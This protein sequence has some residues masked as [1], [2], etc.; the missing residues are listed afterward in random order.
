MRQFNRRGLGLFMPFEV[1]W[2][3][4]TWT[5]LPIL[6]PLTSPIYWDL[7]RFQLGLYSR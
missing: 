6:L 7:V 5:L 3:C 1:F 4:L 2:L